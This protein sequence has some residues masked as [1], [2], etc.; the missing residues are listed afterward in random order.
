M[1][2]S[3]PWSLWNA[4]RPSLAPWALNAGVH[5]AH[6]SPLLRQSARRVIETRRDRG[7]HVTTCNIGMVMADQ[8]RL[9]SHCGP[10]RPLRRDIRVS[11]A[12][13]QVQTSVPPAA[14]VSGVPI[15][16]G[17]CSS[18]VPANLVLRRR[19]LALN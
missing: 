3:V 5:E 9:P 16:A 10:G 6:C 4:E 18:G 8:N 11:I 19:L 1:C 17:I 2:L 15:T 14:A 13:W 12:E 7:H